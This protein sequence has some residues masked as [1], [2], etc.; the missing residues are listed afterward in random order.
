MVTRAPNQAFSFAEDFGK[1]VQMLIQTKTIAALGVVTPGSTTLQDLFDLM[2]CH[3]L[4]GAPT[5]II[6]NSS[7]KK[8][9]FSLVKIK[10]TSFQ[11]FPYIAPNKDFDPLLAHGQDLTEELL[12]ETNNLKTFKEAVVATLLPNFF[13]IYYGQ[14]APHSYITTDKV[15]SKMMHLGTGREEVVVAKQLLMVNP[16][17]L[18]M[19]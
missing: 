19:V 12:K 17:Y 6:G 2:I 11:L 13:V 9:Q 1:A 18:I 5:T 7:N 15:K 14:K 16:S 3:N 8:G 4:S 10:I